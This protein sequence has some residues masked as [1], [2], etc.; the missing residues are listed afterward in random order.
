[1]KDMYVNIYLWTFLPM[2]AVSKEGKMQLN[3][4]SSDKI[5]CDDDLLEGSAVSATDAKYSDELIISS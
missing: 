4:M 5:V 2:N 3:M 1:M